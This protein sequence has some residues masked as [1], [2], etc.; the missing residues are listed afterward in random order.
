MKRPYPLRRATS[1]GLGLPGARNGHGFSSQTIAFDDSEE[2]D[3]IP[4]DLN[5]TSSDSRVS[6][7]FPTFTSPGPIQ[8]SREARTPEGDDDKGLHKQPSEDW[9][10]LNGSRGSGEVEERDKER[11]GWRE[12]DF[13]RAPGGHDINIEVGSVE[14]TSVE[15]DSIRRSGS[16]RMNRSLGSEFDLSFCADKRILIFSFSFP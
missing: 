7:S 14:A 2:T 1:A 16:K 3:K 5:R 6:S 11:M 10:V 9:A 8:F 4:Y 13:R 12:S 15:E